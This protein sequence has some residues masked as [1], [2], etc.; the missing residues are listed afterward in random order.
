VRIPVVASGGAAS[1]EDVLEFVVA[2][3]TAVQIGTALFRRPDLVSAV[4]GEL[5]S[6]LGREGA[7]LSELRGS[8]RHGSAVSCAAGIAPDPRPDPRPE[9]R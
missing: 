6:L 5:R 8:L 2:G 3:A 1:A 7:Q 9:P 4:A